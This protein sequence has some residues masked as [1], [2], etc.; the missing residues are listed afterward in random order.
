MAAVSLYITVT[1]QAK[2]KGKDTAPQTSAHLFKLELSPMATFSCQVAWEIEFLTG[3]IAA[4]N[5]IRVLL[6]RKK[7]DT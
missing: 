1:F 2:D 7:G 3:P 4:L 5:K 6:I